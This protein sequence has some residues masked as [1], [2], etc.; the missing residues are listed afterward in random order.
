MD[1]AASHTAFTQGEDGPRITVTLV[2]VGPCSVA[3]FSASYLPARYSPL[4]FS[5]CRSN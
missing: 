3:G 1:G 2:S 4:F 5:L